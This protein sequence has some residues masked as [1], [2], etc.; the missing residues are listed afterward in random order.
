M[1]SLSEA[2]REEQLNILKRC[3]EIDKYT[4]ALADE[5]KA[6]VDRKDTLSVLLELYENTERSIA[7]S[8]ATRSQIDSNEHNAS[9]LEA[10]TTPRLAAS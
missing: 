10:I 1:L 6:Y 4:A 2:V 7:E 3:E 9:V 8:K 5:R